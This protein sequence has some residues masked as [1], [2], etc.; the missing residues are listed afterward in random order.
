MQNV[1]SSLAF[2]VFNITPR[3]TNTVFVVV[4]RMPHWGKFDVRGLFFVEINRYD[5]TIPKNVIKN[6]VFNIMMMDQNS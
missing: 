5:K 3:G 6:N 4:T 2:A 1:L